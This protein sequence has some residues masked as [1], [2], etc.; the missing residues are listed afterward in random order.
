MIL[1]NINKTL[2]NIPES[3]GYYIEDVIEQKKEVKDDDNTFADL[4]ITV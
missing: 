2:Q 4:I 1:E 3:V